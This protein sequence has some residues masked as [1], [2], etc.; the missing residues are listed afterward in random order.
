MSDGRARRWG[1]IVLP[2]F[3]GCLTLWGYMHVDARLALGLIVFVLALLLLTGALGI[4][5]RPGPAEQ[6]LFLACT[7]IWLLPIVAHLASGALAGL[8][9][10]AALLPLATAVSLA[11]ISPAVATRGE[12]G[13]VSWPQSAAFAATFNALFYL[14][15]QHTAVLVVAVTVAA[16][17]GTSII[18]HWLG[19]RKAAGI[20]QATGMAAVIVGQ[21]ARLASVPYAGFGVFDLSFTALVAWWLLR[22]GLIGARWKSETEDHRLEVAR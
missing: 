5:G 13:P 10:G 21:A 20:V 18:L 2:L 4:T 8:G 3:L 17:M 11:R 7:G 15:A 1:W 12:R 6:F 14:N 16:L 22:D 19:R 9:M